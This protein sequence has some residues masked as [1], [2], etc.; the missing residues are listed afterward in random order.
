MAK[1][2]KAVLAAAKLGSE[3][4]DPPSVPPEPTKP[5]LDASALINGEESEIIEDESISE[6]IRIKVRNKL[7]KAA[8]EAVE[9][10]ITVA[11]GYVSEGGKERILAS[12]AILDRAGFQKG[13]VLTNAATALP[14]E[15]MVAALM[16]IAKVLGKAPDAPNP[17]INVTPEPKVLTHG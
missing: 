5:A 13:L 12:E 9:S 7:L 10:L 1:K 2:K 15:A 6:D 17:T 11:R 16:G 4:S 8:P 3:P 14:M